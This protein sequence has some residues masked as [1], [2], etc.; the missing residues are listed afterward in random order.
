L[1]SNS[2]GTIFIVVAF[3]LGV[4]LFTIGTLMMRKPSETAGESASEYAIEPGEFHEAAALEEVLASF[5]P[6]KPVEPQ[7]PQEPVESAVPEEPEEPVV[8]LP[9]WTAKVAGTDDVLAPE[10]R[11]D[12]IERLAMIG[13]PWCAE[14]LERARDSDPD[15]VVRDAA[16]NALIVIAAR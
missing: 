14:L 3:V 13:E 12:M 9:P 4:L 16:D 7:E 2:S 15:V 11:V 1:L 10:L 6:R 5:E 8:V